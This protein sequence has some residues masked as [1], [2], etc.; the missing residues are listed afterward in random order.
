MWQ[1]YRAL[2]YSV[3]NICCVYINIENIE[4]KIVFLAK[5]KM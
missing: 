5:R 4:W 1:E 3:L 2:N